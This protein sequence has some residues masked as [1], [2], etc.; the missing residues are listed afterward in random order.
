[1]SELLTAETLEKFLAP[2]IETSPLWKNKTLSVS[3]IANPKAGGFTNKKRAEEHLKALQECAAEVKGK[4]RLVSK[5]YFQDI[6]TK[7]AGHAIERTHQI[8]A[9]ALQT[10]DKNFEFLIVIASGDGTSLEVQ[11]AIAKACFENEKNLKTIMKKVAVLRLPFGTGNDG[12]DDRELKLSLR[13]LTKP[14]HFAW[15]KAVKVYYEGKTPQQI[16]EENPKRAKKRFEKYGSLSEVP[17]WYSFNIAS[18]GMDAFVTHMTNKTKRYIHGDYYQIWVD[19]G[20]LFYECKF[21]VAKM[22]IEFYD[23]NDKLIGQQNKK[24]MLALLGVSGNRQ[25]GSNHKILPGN[26]TF[27]SIDQMG[28]F[29]KMKRRNFLNEGEHYKMDWATFKDVA[30]IKI[31]YNKDILTQLDGEVHLIQKEQFPLVMEHTCP[32][33]K[34]IECDDNKIY[35]GAEVVKL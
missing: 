6:E 21:P 16:I 8:I 23:K 29:D 31:Y 35:K 5:L 30:K 11:S 27:C 24:I 22:K 10:K 3:I 2:L 17:P 12:S 13:R 34:I 1:M 19:L 9:E 33:I 25:Y 28:L 4:P 14:S 26:E 18:V 7:Y 20:C 15:Q 32:L